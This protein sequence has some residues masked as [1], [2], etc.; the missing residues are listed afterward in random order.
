MSRVAKSE[1][2]QRLPADEIREAAYRVDVAVRALDEL[3]GGRAAKLSRPAVDDLLD[4]RGRLDVI[5]GGGGRS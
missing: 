5:L 4:A 1:V 3:L 2:G